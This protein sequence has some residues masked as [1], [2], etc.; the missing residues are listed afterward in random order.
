MAGVDKESHVDIIKSGNTPLIEFTEA[1][2]NKNALDLK[3][4]RGTADDEYIVISHVW[5]RTAVSND[6]LLS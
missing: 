2:N 5:P 4:V 6:T 3:L 1:N